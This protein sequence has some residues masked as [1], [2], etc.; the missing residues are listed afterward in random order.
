MNHRDCF[1][2]PRIHSNIHLPI[3]TYTD[4]FVLDCKGAYNQVTIATEENVFWM[5]CHSIRTS[6]K[7]ITFIMFKMYDFMLLNRYKLTRETDRQTDIDCIT[8]MMYG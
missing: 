2:F 1:E 8:N 5:L 7:R 3:Q 6:L 4:K